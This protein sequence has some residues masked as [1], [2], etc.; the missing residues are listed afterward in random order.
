[1]DIGDGNDQWEMGIEL[2]RLEIRETEMGWGRRWDR[3]RIAMC[4][5]YGE[6][7][8][9]VHAP[10]N[11]FPLTDRPVTVL[12][13]HRPQPGEW[14]VMVSRSPFLGPLRAF[15]SDTHTHTHTQATAKTPQLIPESRVQTRFSGSVRLH[16]ARCRLPAEDWS[17]HFIF[18]VVCFAS[19][20]LNH[21]SLL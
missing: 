19:H 16:V 6:T 11:Q 10:R 17:L 9:P 1:M 21:T 2:M 5:A 7:F 20:R 13:V 14:G 18:Q 4:M 3:M 8:F 12:S 15:G